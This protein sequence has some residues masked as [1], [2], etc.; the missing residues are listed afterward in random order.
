MFLNKPPTVVTVHWYFL[1][2]ATCPIRLTK[3]SQVNHMRRF[4]LVEEGIRRIGVS[5]QA[6]PQHIRI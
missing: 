6:R 2:S 3:G 4:V 1:P 5:A